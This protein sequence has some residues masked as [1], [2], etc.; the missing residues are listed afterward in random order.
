VVGAVSASVI[1]FMGAFAG[2]ATNNLA[3]THPAIAV[4]WH[5]TRD[6]EL[7]AAQVTPKSDRRVWWQCEHGHEWQTSVANRAAPIRCRRKVL[8]T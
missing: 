1:D 8:S 7:T 6:G 5:P 3:V 2:H 4:A